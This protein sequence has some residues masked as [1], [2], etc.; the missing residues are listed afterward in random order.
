MAKYGQYS[1]QPA[2]KQRPWEIHPVWRGIG[3][4]LMILIPVISYAA[5][6]LIVRENLDQGWLPIPPQLARTIILPYFG[7]V[8]YFFATL[9]VAALLA[10]VGFGLIT[11]LYAL[12]YGLV[13][14]SRYGPLDAPPEWGRPNRRR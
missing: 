12:V 2:Q 3:C 1:R 14:P 5:A 7:S 4:I 8:P 10:L 13:G 6:V 9:I 11:A